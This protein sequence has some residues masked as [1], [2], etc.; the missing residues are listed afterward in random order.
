MSDADSILELGTGPQSQALSVSA[1]PYLGVDSFLPY[2]ESIRKR[3][4]VRSGNRKVEVIQADI[5][6]LDF[7]PK[8]FSHIVMIDVLEHL[9]REAGEQLLERL[10]VWA[11]RAVIIKTPNGFVAQNALDDNPL[12]EHVSGWTVRD[13]VDRGYKVEGLSG[14]R[15][16][17]REVHLHDW[18]SDLS[19]TMRWRPRN[20]WLGVA[21]LSQLHCRVRP[22]WAFELLAVRRL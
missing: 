5:L 18:T 11:S 9:N 7:L 22:K 15:Y 6:S 12:Q 14:Y 21:G 19:A 1:A 10:S 3:Q 17:R 2:L 8:S 20:F 13:F 16:L 4:V